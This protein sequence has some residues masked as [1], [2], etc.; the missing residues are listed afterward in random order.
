VFCHPQTSGPYDRKRY[1]D[2]LRAALA[3][4]KV[5]G[6]VRPFHDGR[7]TAL[8]NI[9]AAGVPPAALQA[10]ARRTDTSTTQ[11]YIDL[12]GVHFRAEAELA[13][14]R[15]FGAVATEDGAHGGA[16]DE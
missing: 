7:H 4:A 5:A 11:R 2:T 9:A 16:H 3:K 10:G 12:A 14:R 1:A 13:E 6:H 15:L 8:T